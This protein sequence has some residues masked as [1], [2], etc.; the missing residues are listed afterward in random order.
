MIYPNTFVKTADNTGV[1]LIKC[2]R[3][4]NKQNK[5]RIKRHDNK[6]NEQFA[7]CKRYRRQDT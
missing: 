6:L 5:G 7:K 2:I 3:V 1:K 4:Y